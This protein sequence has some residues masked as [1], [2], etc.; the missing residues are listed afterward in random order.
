[1][2]RVSVSLS[3]DCFLMFTVTPSPTP[4]PRQLIIHLITC[5]YIRYAG[6]SPGADQSLV[7][8]AFQELSQFDMIKHG[9]DQNKFR[10]AVAQNPFEPGTALPSRILGFEQMKTHLLDQGKKLEA[11]EN[12]VFIRLLIYD[13]FAVHFHPLV[14]DMKTD[15]V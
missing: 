11:Q 2:D 5:P 6:I 10:Q 3:H 7:R 8:A 12:E 4:R 15:N 14:S 1:M 13:T 9:P